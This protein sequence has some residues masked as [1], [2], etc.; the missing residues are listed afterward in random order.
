[1]SSS[2]LQLFCAVVRDRFPEY[3]RLVEPDA[4]AALDLERNRFLDVPGDL[5]DGGPG[6]GFAAA[7][8]DENGETVT[9][10][11]RVEPRA[12][13]AVELM[14]LLGRWLC[15][16]RIS[17]GRPLLVHL[18]SLQGA[19]P[20]N[21]LEMAV[22]ARAGGQEAVRVFYTQ[23]GLAAAC[24]EYYLERAEPLCWALAAWMHPVCCDPGELRNACRKKIAAATLP[25]ESRT[26]LLELVQAAEVLGG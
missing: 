7:V 11:I 4:A 3:L 9:V 26:L 19:R 23:F 12:P 10:L 6:L 21:N 24:A 8:P 15:A 5:D 16:L 1:M 13:E 18:L 22:L 25:R 17:Y 14:R 20:G 2:N